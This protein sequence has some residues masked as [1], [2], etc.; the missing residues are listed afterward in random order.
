MELKPADKV[1]IERTVN[2]GYFGPM[3]VTHY[4]IYVGPME[5]GVPSVVE[6]TIH[7]GTQ[8]VPLEHFKNHGINFRYES[9]TPEASSF[10]QDE[11]IGRALSHVG[12]SYYDF[13][14]KNCEHF[15]DWCWT[16]QWRSKQVQAGVKLVSNLISLLPRRRNN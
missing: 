14:H 12:E 11:V 6:N 2:T 9:H 1:L 8:V 7:S 16:D 4:G 5:N 10:T 3:K 15:A 13:F